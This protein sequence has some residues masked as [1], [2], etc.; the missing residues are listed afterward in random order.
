ML[1]TMKCLIKYIAVQSN[2]KYTAT[3]QQNVNN[4]T[5][6]T[7]YEELKRLSSVQTKAA[8]LSS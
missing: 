7:V 1:I 2:L 8:I 5:F 6:I 4:D 3:I